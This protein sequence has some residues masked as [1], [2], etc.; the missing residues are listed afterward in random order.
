MKADRRQASGG[1]VIWTV[2][3]GLECVPLTPIA[4]LSQGNDRVGL[5]D[6]TLQVGSSTFTSYF[7]ITREERPVCYQI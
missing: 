7:T 6:V 2:D 5:T 3:C 4:P 1:M